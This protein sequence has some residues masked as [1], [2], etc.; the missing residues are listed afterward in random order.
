MDRRAE[1]RP[2]APGLELRRDAVD[3]NRR[4]RM[5]R[6]GLLQPRLTIMFTRNIIIGIVV[7]V[8]VLFTVG[9]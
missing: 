8:V 1:S 6:C 4:H 7:A 3:R 5:G 2:D 9:L